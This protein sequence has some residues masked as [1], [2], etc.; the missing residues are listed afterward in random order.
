MNILKRTISLCPECYREIPA[1]IVDCGTIRMVKECPEHGI[2]NATMEKDRLFYLSTQHPASD[3]YAGHFVDVTTRCNMKCQ[4]CYFP[5]GDAD[6]PTKLII[7]ECLVNNGPYI[8]T[9]GEPTVRDDLPDLMEKISKIGPV[10]LISNGRA[11]A[12]SQYLSECAKFAFQDD[13]CSYVNVSF[14]GDEKVF[15]EAMQSVEYL[16]LRLSSILFVID[17]VEQ[18]GDVVR[19]AKKYK[20]HCGIVRIKAA[21]NVW[22]QSGTEKIFASDILQWFKDRGAVQV[23][24][25]AKPVY[26]PFLF[27]GISYAAVS[28][29]DVGNVDLVEINCAPTYRAKNGQ[30]TDLI[31][32]FLINEGMDK[33]WLNGTRC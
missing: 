17:D 15:C 6:I 5:C 21:S 23:Y 27:E 10:H 3:L 13:F 24:P 14:H 32:A 2:F 1:A 31:R 4:Y 28:W 30:V 26:A 7:N 33:G 16:G 19:Y 25:T 11:F 12:D 20:D 8:L 29:H 22:A 9:G 18:I